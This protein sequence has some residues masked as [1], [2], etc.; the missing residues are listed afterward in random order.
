MSHVF[1]LGLF[2]LVLPP[3]LRRGR[4]GRLFRAFGGTALSTAVMAGVLYLVTRGLTGTLVPES[5]GMRVVVL[6]GA[7]VIGAAVYVGAAR[8]FAR[9]E[10]AETLQA[11]RDGVGDVLHKKRRSASR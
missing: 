1:K 7:A 6:G 10:L 3:V 9:T 4:Y 2:L 11:V 8:L 5:L